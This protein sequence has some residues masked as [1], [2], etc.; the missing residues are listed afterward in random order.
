MRSLLR[1]VLRRALERSTRLR[2]AVAGALGRHL[3]P[4]DLDFLRSLQSGVTLD[5]DRQLAY[6][7]SGTPRERA[8][9]SV[10]WSMLWE[11]SAARLHGAPCPAR[12]EFRLRGRRFVMELD[13]AE[14]PECGYLVR[15]PTV[16]LT[17]QLLVG[18]DTMLDV[19]ANAGFH[20]LTAACFFRRVL[21]FEP[22]PETAARLE[23][24]VTLSGAANVR[25]ERVAL[26]NRAGESSLVVNPSHCGANR[27]GDGDGARVPLRRLDDVLAE[28][29]DAATRI[30]FVK[31]DVEGHECEVAEGAQATFARHTPTLFVEF[32]SADQFA[33]FRHLLPDPYR[34]FR[35]DVD[36]T[37]T[38]IADGAQAVAARDV[39]FLVP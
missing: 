11:A 6:R 7:S 18:G 2:G 14:C 26:S 12:V 5:L 13:L 36:G 10:L 22:T 39:T 19:G 34:A 28:C 27:I 21:A 4:L 25:V 37:R 9:D 24:N 32:N 23:R 17:A 35:V 1:T 3:T 29:G 20:A 15:N 8:L 33:R 31:I 16:E 30:D 38:A